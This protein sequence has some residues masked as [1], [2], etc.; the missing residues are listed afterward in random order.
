MQEQQP[1]PSVSDVVSIADIFFK[2]KELERNGVDVIHLDVGE[3]DY[4]PPP[5]VVEATSGALRSGWGRYTVASGIPEV[6]NAIAEHV[7]SKYG[8][9]FS[10]NH[11]LFT[12]GGRLALFLAFVSLPKD[13]KV[14]IISPDWP[15]YRDLCGFLSFKTVFFNTKLEN[16]WEPDLSEIAESGC[17]ALVLNYPNNPTGK[18][19]NPRLFDEL[20]DLAKNHNMKI[21][22]DEVYSDF[23]LDGSSFK[24]V[25]QT[26]RSADF[27]FTT[28]LSK[29]YSMTGYRAAYLVS[30]ERT[31]SRLS[32]INGLIL[33]SAPEFVQHGAIAAL[34]SNEYVR[35]KVEM[36]K[37]RLDAACKT[38]KEIGADFYRSDGSL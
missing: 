2:S 32:Q 33:T 7:N 8:T 13:S 16:G 29:S 26:E 23:L 1:A 9:R 35:S 31:V 34:K 17:N 21:I 12:S 5:E 20:M 28:S 22:S 27:I 36:V 10:S 25:L 14:G 15:A 6:R 4:E 30:D 37:K 24:S 19:L 18:I 38:L 11:V 3:P